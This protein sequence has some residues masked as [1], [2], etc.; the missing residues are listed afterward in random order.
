MIDGGN[1]WLDGWVAGKDWMAVGG[2]EKGEGR[3]ERKCNDK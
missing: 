2:K 1:G 3:K